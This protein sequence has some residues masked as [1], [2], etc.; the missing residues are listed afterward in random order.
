MRRELKVGKL[1]ASHHYTVLYTDVES[2]ILGGIGTFSESPVWESNRW[3]RK[4][5]KPVQFIIPGTPMLVL[6]APVSIE[7]HDREYVK[8]L[9]TDSNG[10][11]MTGWVDTWPLY[12]TLDK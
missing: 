1:Y 5:G 4:I 11:E 7:N 12:V 6:E 2:A 8:I 10:Y 3:S 9:T